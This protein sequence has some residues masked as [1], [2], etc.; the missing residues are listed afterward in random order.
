[1]MIAI[2]NGFKKI[3]NGIGNFFMR[4]RKVFLVYL[5]ISLVAGALFHKFIDKE[6]LSAMVIK[7]MFLETDY[8]LEMLENI[9]FMAIEKNSELLSQTLKIEKP[10]AENFIG[11]TYQYLSES[12]NDDDTISSFAPIR[13]AVHLKE[14]KYHKEIQ[15]ALVKFLEGNNYSRQVTEMNEYN[16]RMNKEK[17][18]RQVVKLDSLGQTMQAKLKQPS[19][20]GI[21]LVIEDKLNPA[22]VFREEFEMYSMSV[23]LDSKIKMNNAFIVM[24]DLYPSPKAA[25]PKLWHSLL[26]SGILFLAL[27]LMTSFLALFSKKKE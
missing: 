25:F 24:S 19:N 17:L 16:L 27:V 6:Y 7:P 23:T 22:E 10:I 1:M 18:D 5:I 26:F 8:C 4:Y 13:L 2:G 9:A 21:K 15:E 3:G 11:L 14:N 20:D 12:K